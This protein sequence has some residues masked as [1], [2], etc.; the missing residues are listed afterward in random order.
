MATQCAQRGQVRRPLTQPEVLKPRPPA[1][2]AVAPL[3][4]AAARAG[5]SG[6]APGIEAELDAITGAEPAVGREQR[7]GG[8]DYGIALEHRLS[9]LRQPLE[10]PRKIGRS[11]YQ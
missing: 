10:Q 8:G 1:I 5:M 3:R 4:G 9:P 11:R 6:G 2:M 7:L